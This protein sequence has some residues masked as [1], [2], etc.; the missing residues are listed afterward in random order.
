MYIMRLVKKTSLSEQPQV[1]YRRAVRG[2]PSSTHTGVTFIHLSPDANAES[3]GRSLLAA[4]LQL[5][6]HESFSVGVGRTGT[7]THNGPVGQTAAL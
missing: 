5:G 3:D 4:A 6:V 2:E 7:H 1:C